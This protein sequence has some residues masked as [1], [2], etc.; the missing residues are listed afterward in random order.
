MDF[1]Q[2]FIA[3]TII[4]LHPSS[5]L[6]MNSGHC[7]KWAK[8]LVNFPWTNNGLIDCGY[9][10]S[11]NSQLSKSNNSLLTNQRTTVFLTQYPNRGMKN[12]GDSSIS[13]I[14]NLL[15]WKQKIHCSNV[16]HTDL[17]WTGLLGGNGAKCHSGTSH[18]SLLVSLRKS[19][20]S[21]NQVWE[22]LSLVS[23]LLLYLM[24]WV[25][26]TAALV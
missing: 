25:S 7:C 15:Q 9:K 13:M 2:H 21:V 22:S 19:T 16:H 14:H 11:H 8:C 12:N 26:I 6:N 3:M 17:N 1:F 10:T 20:Y 18:K 5:P 24:F 23:V 4:Y